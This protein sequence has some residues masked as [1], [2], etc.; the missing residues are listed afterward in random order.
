LLLDYPLVWVDDQDATVPIDQRIPPVV[1][2]TWEDRYFGRRHAEEMRQFR[3][4]N[5]DLSFK[6]FD[7][8]S[9]D[10]Y[11]TERWQDHAIYAVYANSLFGSMKADIF[12]FCIL[13]DRGGYYFDIG[14]GCRKPLTS[15]HARD[16]SG[17]I[18]FE[19]NDLF[20]PPCHEVFGLLSYPL[21]YALMW[22]LAFEQNHRI[23]EMMIDRIVDYYPL[24]RNVIFENPKSGILALASTGMYTSVV[25]DYF[26]TSDAVGIKQL[27]IY[28]ESYGIFALRGSEFRN[29][30]V[31]HTTTAR[32]SVICT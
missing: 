16:C 6:L 3:A 20:L 22:G 15:L 24:F 18:T 14:K 2:Q 30:R 9:R 23:P 10:A 1:Y 32:H 17:L 8:E 13:F 28:F 25:R 29:R 31:P 12:R 4:L 21:K 11:M 19:D 7:R 26:A 5:P 27:G